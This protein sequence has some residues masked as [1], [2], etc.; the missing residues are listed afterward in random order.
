MKTGRRS[1]MPIELAAMHGHARTLQVFFRLKHVETR[2]LLPH[3]L[4]VACRHGRTRVALLV[5]SECQRT[6]EGIEEAD[7]DI[8]GAITML[9]KHFRGEIAAAFVFLL[10]A[11]RPKGQ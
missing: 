3:L 2:L 7:A 4:K 11:F 8:P 6:A 9:L 10:V 5:L 1:L